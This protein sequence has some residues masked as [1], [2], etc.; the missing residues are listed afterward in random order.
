V[1]GAAAPTNLAT[2]PLPHPVVAAWKADQTVAMLF[3]HDGGIDDRLVRQASAQLDGMSGVT[4]F[5]VP[6]D[7]IADYAAITE[8]VG[9]DRV[10]ALV[11]L[12]PKRLDESIPTASVTY[13]FQNGASVKQAVID[14]GYEGPTLEYHP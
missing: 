13:G 12:R 1:E 3:V 14:A 4:T 7:K 5:V 9:V 8:G 6:A 2:R 10:P 11:V